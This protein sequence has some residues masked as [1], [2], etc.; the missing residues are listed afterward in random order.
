MAVDAIGAQPA[1]PGKG[2]A[3]DAA[4]AMRQISTMGR[5]GRGE[6]PAG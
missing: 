6:M 3:E 1:T 2:E 5:G 4:Y